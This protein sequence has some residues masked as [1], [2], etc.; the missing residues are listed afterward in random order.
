MDEPT[1]TQITDVIYAKHQNLRNVTGDITHMI[2]TAV[3]SLTPNQAVAA[4]LIRGIWFIYVKSVKSRLSLLQRGY[5]DIGAHALF[6]YGENPYN[7]KSRVPNER[8]VI[9]DLPIFEPDD[10]I[11]NFLADYP[12]IQPV[13]PLDFVKPRSGEFINGDRFIYVKGEFTPPLPKDIHLG[14]HPCRLWHASQ[15]LECLR[16][17]QPTHSTSDTEKCSAYLQSQENIIAFKHPRNALTNY[18][19]CDLTFQGQV[20]N[21]A[22]QA[23]QWAK[24]TDLVEPELAERIFNSASPSQ[25]KKISEEILPGKDFSEWNKKKYAVMRAILESK[26]K[27]SQ[28]YCDVLLKSGNKLLVEATRDEW[29]GANTSPH[30]AKTTNPIFYRGQN[31][32][33]LL[34]MEIREMLRAIQDESPNPMQ[35]TTGTSVNNRVIPSAPP[36]PP[37]HPPTPPP[38]PPTPPPPQLRDNFNKLQNPVI[39]LLKA[40]DPHKSKV[41]RIGKPKKRMTTQKRYSLPSS[42][43]ARKIHHETSRTS[44]FLTRKQAPKK[45]KSLEFVFVPTAST[46]SHVDSASE[47][48]DASSVTSYVSASTG[49]MD[50]NDMPVN[51]PPDH[52]L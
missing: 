5:L 10:L 12:Q 23:Y 39:D 36:I 18:Y 41:K 52:I 13:G 43:S 27:S 25:A 14:D 51:P 35:H 31:R 28:R 11:L 24:C 37:P 45:P 42:S 7:Y 17:H 15:K 46:S 33:G 26:A 3:N 49:V 48:D 8:V 50:D 34:H 1:Y 44:G 9:R 6:L 32:L 21:S 29:W 47:Y 40:N 2:C 4:Q 20:F 16:C 22:E 38:P 30:L 19:V